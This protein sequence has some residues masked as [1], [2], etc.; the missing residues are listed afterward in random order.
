MRKIFVL[1]AMF[2]S[3]LS[4]D[5]EYKYDATGTFESA[6]VTVSSEVSGKI[7]SVDVDEGD[8]VKNGQLLVVVDTTAL[9][10]QRNILVRQQEAVLAGKPD[11]QKQVSSLR[12]QIRK[13]ETELVR[14]ERMQKGEAATKK[15][16]DDV[17]AQLEVL[18]SQ[19][20]ASLQSL[21]SNV[22][23][24]DGNAAA[25]NAQIKLIDDQ[26]HRSYILSPVD[27]TVLVRYVQ[28]GEMT[29]VGKPM[30]R[31][32]DMDNMYLRAYFTS[33]QLPSVSVGQNVKVIADF[34][35]DK[36]YEY[37]GTIVW[38]SEESE[39]TPKGI[40]TNDSRANLVYA[41]KIAVKNDG[42]LKIGLHGMV[43]L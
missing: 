29:T 31:I 5:S 36:Q 15:Q 32:A 2:L 11:I 8:K 10:L 35:A 20:D 30:M 4:C 21:N 19:L 14:L 18:Q 37:E 7:I 23:T 3:V 9:V 39:F 24:I 16:V 34:G 42:K 13:Q 41:T 6:E 43:K 38:I 26:I 27:G 1:F 22:A 17:K 40:Q 28:K 12:N 33:E 25:L